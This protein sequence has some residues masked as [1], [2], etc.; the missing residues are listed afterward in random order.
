MTIML[1]HTIVPARDKET[2]ARFFAQLFG[3]SFEG[4]DGHFAR[5]VSTKLSRC[6]STTT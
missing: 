6:S 1:N 5:C 3:L 4:Q 2:S